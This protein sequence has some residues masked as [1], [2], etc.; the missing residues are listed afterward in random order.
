MEYPYRRSTN[1]CGT[2]SNSLMES[3]LVSVHALGLA[4]AFAS[5]DHCMDVV[6]RAYLLISTEQG[7]ICRGSRA[8]VVADWR[9]V[10]C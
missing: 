5:G 8:W 1:A 6:S 3:S 4:V 2:R 9:K 7:V 10:A